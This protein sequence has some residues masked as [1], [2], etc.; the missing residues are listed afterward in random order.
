MMDIKNTHQ[1]KKSILSFSIIVFHRNKR[2]LAG[3]LWIPNDEVYNKSFWH[4]LQI[5][6][7][8]RKMDLAGWFVSMTH[9]WKKVLSFCLRVNVL[10]YTHPS[11]Q[12]PAEQSSIILSPSV[13]EFSSFV[14]L[15]VGNTLF[16]SW[17]YQVE[18]GFSFA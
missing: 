12:V 9:G 1:L 8:K 15:S 7:S 2:A 14:Q 5:S 3:I 17:T 6:E 4:L 10:L 11:L 16:T 18:I 13:D